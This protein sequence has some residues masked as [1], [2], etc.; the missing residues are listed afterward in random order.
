MW[1]TVI[2]EISVTLYQLWAVRGLLSYKEL[3]SNSWRYLLS[4]IIMFIPVFW[5]N[6][7]LQ[8]SWLMMGLE[9]VIGIIIYGLMT[10][11][12]KAPILKQLKT[13]ISKKD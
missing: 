10:I 6:Q 1:S 5:M 7:N 11:I 8:D 12:L 4:G 3:F 13:I 2:S 9:V